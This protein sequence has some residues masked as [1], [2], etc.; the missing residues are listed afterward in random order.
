MSKNMK[1]LE[2]VF[3]HIQPSGIFQDKNR[4]YN[5]QAHTS[6]GQ[7][8]KQ[9]VKGLTMRDIADCVRIAIWES[10]FSPEDAASIFDVDLSEVDPVAIEQN[11]ACNIE[12]M[13]GIYPNIRNLESS[14]IP[15]I[16]LDWDEE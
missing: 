13:M 11:V 1:K 6:R 5:G 10:A 16:E 4:P 7:R 2:E 9:E 15:M 12:N 14:D 3:E 8:G